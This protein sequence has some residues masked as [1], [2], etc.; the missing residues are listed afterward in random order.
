MTDETTR[1]EE[2]RSI[3]LQW[4]GEE[5]LAE[6]ARYLAVEVPA[7]ASGWWRA[8]FACYRDFWTSVPGSAVYRP[9]T[10]Q[11]CGVPDDVS[12][13]AQLRQLRMHV[14]ISGELCRWKW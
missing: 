4:E 8:T 14:K 13:A 2:Q 9:H 5:S 6:V 7:H 10:A 11:I 1:A 3:V 12:K